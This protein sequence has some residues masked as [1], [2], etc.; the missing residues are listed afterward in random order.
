MRIV[1][2]A[3]ALA[4]IALVTT[5]DASGDGKTGEVMFNRNDKILTWQTNNSG[6]FNLTDKMGM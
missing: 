3:C 4:G 1:I 6:E 5:H 2:V